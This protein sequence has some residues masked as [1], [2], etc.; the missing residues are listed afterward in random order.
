MGNGQTRLEQK[1]ELGFS[2]VELGFSAVEH[3]LS[4]V[5]HKI[6]CCGKSTSA[7]M[8][9]TAT[10]ICAAAD[11]DICTDVDYYIQCLA[12]QMS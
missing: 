5:E 8:S 10:D 1:L 2:A 6:D 11:D 12:V 3:K 4:A 7:Q 9:Y